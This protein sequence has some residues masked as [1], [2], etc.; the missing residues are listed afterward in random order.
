[1]KATEHNHLGRVVLGSSRSV[2]THITIKGFE[3][4]QDL[5]IKGNDMLPPESTTSPSRAIVLNSCCK[6]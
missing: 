3:E 2:V 5:H 6:S 4:T 1:M